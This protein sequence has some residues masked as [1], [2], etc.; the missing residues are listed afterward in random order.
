MFKCTFLHPLKCSAHWSFSGWSWWYN[1]LTRSERLACWFFHLSAGAIYA[2]WLT[3]QDARRNQCFKDLGLDVIRLLTLPVLN[4]Y[5]ERPFSQATWLKGDIRNCTGLQSPP[6]V[7]QLLVVLKKILLIQ[8]DH[9]GSDHRSQAQQKPRFH[10]S[11]LGFLF[12]YSHW[13]IIL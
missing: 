7:R 2:F 13:L 3:F 12:P 11:C 1:K 5:V 4:H 8:S 6:I 9:C 10:S